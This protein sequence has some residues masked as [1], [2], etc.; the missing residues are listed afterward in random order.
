M[1]QGTS[2]REQRRRAREYAAK[3]A[4][5]ELQH[6]RSSRDNRRSLIGLGVVA[7]ATAALQVAFFTIGPGAT[8]PAQDAAA[9]TS[10]TP[11]A[12]ETTPAANVPDPSLAESRTW[13]GEMTINGIALDVEY[14]G[15]KA[16]QAVANAVSLAQS[17]FYEGTPC[18]RLTTEGIFV[19]QCGDPTGKGTG[20]PGYQWG[21]IENAPKDDLYPAGTIAMA[22]QGGNA[23]S[24]GSQFFIVTEDSTIPS[25]SAGGY[26]IMG[27]VTKGLDELTAQVTDKGVKDGTGDGEPA[28]ATTLEK[29]ELK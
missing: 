4:V 21:P 22:R 5:H 6:E 18:H 25:D 19:L 15:A 26:T 3:K 16:P 23:E 29:L 20:G 1:A 13:K 14:D 7:F 24:M 2:N 12:A 27:K 8:P 17:G 10:T 9:Q 28:V 11:A